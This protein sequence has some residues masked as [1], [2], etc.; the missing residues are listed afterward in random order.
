MWLS[1]G[2]QNDGVLRLTVGGVARHF[3]HL[4]SRDSPFGKGEK[5]RARDLF[6]E[7]GLPSEF[8]RTQLRQLGIAPA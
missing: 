3:K 7:I 1:C 5:E 6:P 2:L 4:R 8:Q